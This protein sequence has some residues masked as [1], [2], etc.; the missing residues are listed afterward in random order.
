MAFLFDTGIFSV[1][2]LDSAIEVG[3]KLYWYV[4][5]TATPVD[6]YSNPELTVPNTNPVL[7]GADGRFPTMFLAPGDY[8]YILT[9]ADSTPADPLHTQDDYNVPDTPPSFDPDLDDFLAGDVPLPVASGGTGAT[10]A[11][12]AR[13]NLG[14][15]ATTGGNVSG[16][17][18]RTSKGVHLFWETAALNNGNVFLVEEGDPN[19]A[20]LPG[21]ITF[22]YTP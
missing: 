2:G 8:K 22:F 10:S 18:T 1:I 3:A 20:T 19:P 14:A 5:D 7:A 13:T 9:A 11:V 6:T 15:F 17:I 16:N 4:A 21:Q 12:N